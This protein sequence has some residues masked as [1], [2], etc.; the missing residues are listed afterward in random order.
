MTIDVRV[1]FW[2]IVYNDSVLRMIDVLKKE[3]AYKLLML[4]L[5]HFLYSTDEDR[6][7]TNYEAQVY[8]DGLSQE[9]VAALIN[10][11]GRQND[12]NRTAKE[13]LGQVKE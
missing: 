8:I 9:E 1:D 4:Q 7:L 13:I 10:E 6:Y 2:R 5:Q 12:I 11:S 3:Y